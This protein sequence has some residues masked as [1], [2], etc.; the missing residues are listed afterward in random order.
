MPK[1]VVIALE[2][3]GAIHSTK[4]SEVWFENFLVSNGSLRVRTL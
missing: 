2:T 1:Y 4:I 3:E